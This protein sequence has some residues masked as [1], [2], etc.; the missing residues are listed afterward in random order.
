MNENNTQVINNYHIDGASL[1]K[2]IAS[3]E[4]VKLLSVLKQSNVILEQ[5]DGLYAVSYDNWDT[6]G[7]EDHQPA[8]SLKRITTNG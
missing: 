5:E 8:I 1:I 3:Q 7:Q 4:Q 2:I 6:R